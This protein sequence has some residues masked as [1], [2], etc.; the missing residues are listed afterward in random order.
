MV[1]STTCHL[2]RLWAYAPAV[3]WYW[4]GDSCFNLW[5]GRHYNLTSVTPTKDDGEGRELFIR[6][7]QRVCRILGLRSALLKHYALVT[8]RRCVTTQLK[9]GLIV[10]Q[11]SL[12]G[13]VML[14]KAL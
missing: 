13:T 11:E 7:A 1:T 4:V 2:A 10:N 5:E 8:I 6:R 9:T 12:V 3:S 14:D